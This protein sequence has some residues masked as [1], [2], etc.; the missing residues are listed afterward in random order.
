MNKCIET[1]NDAYVELDD[2]FWPPYIEM[3][4]RCGIVQRHPENELRIKLTAYHL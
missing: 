3:L 1:P 2:T 4:I